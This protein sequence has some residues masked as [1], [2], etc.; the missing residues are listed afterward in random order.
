MLLD[1]DRE[2]K[3][4]RNVVVNKSEN[5]EKRNTSQKVDKVNKTYQNKEDE[6]VE[7]LLTTAGTFTFPYFTG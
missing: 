3:E 7:K 5:S 6:F 1:K 4:E 2:S